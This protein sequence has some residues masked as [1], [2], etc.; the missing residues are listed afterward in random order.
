MIFRQKK[1]KKKEKIYKVLKIIIF[2]V[3]FVPQSQHPSHII[4]NN[5]YHPQLPNVIPNAQCHPVRKMSSRTQNVIPYAKCHPVRK[6]SSRTPN[7]IL[8]AALLRTHLLRRMIRDLIFLS[9]LYFL[10]VI[11]TKKLLMKIVDKNAC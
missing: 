5:M 2:W 6:M 8:N 4:P 9:L 1:I 7:V 10:L 11:S 3:D